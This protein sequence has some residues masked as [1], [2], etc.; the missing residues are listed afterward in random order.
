[1]AAE[2]AGR[3]KRR[4][5]SKE[6]AAVKYDSRLKAAFE[7]KD[8]LVIG[9]EAGILDAGDTSTGRIMIQCP[10]PGP[11][12]VSGEGS[13]ISDHY[14]DF[15]VV[16]YRQYYIDSNSEAQEVCIEFMSR[17]P[18]STTKYFWKEEGDAGFEK[19]MWEM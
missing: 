10:V 6:T 12:Q 8:S 9:Y 17:L 14:M 1:M 7:K 2:T 15:V 18:D 13:S 3:V 4:R 19:P 11:V 16:L 5:E